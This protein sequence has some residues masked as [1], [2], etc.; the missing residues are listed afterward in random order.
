MQ[1]V[2]WY[3]LNWE[4]Y[5]SASTK[6]KI[7]TQCTSDVSLTYSLAD[8]RYNLTLE[9]SNIFDRTVYDNYMLQKPGR[10]FMAKFRLF[11]N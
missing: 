2:H 10:A 4:T 9:C 11:I 3:Y 7:P 1:W 8:G 6:A 5:G